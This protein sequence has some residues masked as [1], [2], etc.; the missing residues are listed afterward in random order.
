M[1]HRKINWLVVVMLLVSSSAFAVINY[2]GNDY[3]EKM[4]PVS[5]SGTVAE[6]YVVMG[7][8]LSI[9]SNATSNRNTTTFTINGADYKGVTGSVTASADD[10]YYI[11]HQGK[12]AESGFTIGGTN[13][14]TT[15]T[16]TSKNAPFAQ[17]GAGSYFFSTT[18]AIDSVVTSNMDF[19]LINNA[20]YSNQTVTSIPAKI[21][22]TY[23][24]YYG[25]TNSSGSL[26]VTRYTP[27]LNVKLFMEGGL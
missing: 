13:D 12:K 23:Y 22:G 20:N 19:F 26:N 27:E 21:N 15:Q 18:D 16:H 6:Y 25:T 5:G 24:F 10:R 14:W 2:S 4:L 3:T 1:K 9:T 8:S 11:Y 7:T 17:S